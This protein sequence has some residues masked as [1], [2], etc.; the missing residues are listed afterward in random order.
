METTGPQV[1]NAL[2]SH[3]LLRCY[4][5]LVLWRLSERSRGGD[6][7]QEKTEIKGIGKREVI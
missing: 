1:K 7:E 6:E 2:L 5:N 4:L 3:D